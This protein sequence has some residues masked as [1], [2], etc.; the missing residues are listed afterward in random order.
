MKPAINAAISLE[1][2][3]VSWPI[4]INHKER[5][6]VAKVAAIILFVINIVILIIGF[7]WAIWPASVPITIAKRIIGVAICFGPRNTAVRIMATE[8]LKDPSRGISTTI[9][10]VIKIETENKT[11]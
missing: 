5:A 6:I 11:I 1:K 3:T 10:S 8:A 9:K 2:N 7:F 4:R